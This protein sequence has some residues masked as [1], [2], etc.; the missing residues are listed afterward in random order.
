MT[1][2]GFNVQHGPETVQPTEGAWPMASHLHEVVLQ[3]VKC[4]KG[5]MDCTPMST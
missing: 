1:L 5:L 4:V 2:L 3:V